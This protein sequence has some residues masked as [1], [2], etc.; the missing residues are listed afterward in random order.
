M[1]SATLKLSSHRL[2]VSG[3]QAKIFFF[4]IICDFC[5]TNKIWTDPFLKLH[6]LCVLLTTN[7]KNTDHRW[8]REYNTKQDVLPL[9]LAYIFTI[10]LST[11]GATGGLGGGGGGACP[12][13]A[14]SMM[15]RSERILLYQTKNRVNMPDTRKC[16]GLAR[17]PIQLNSSPTLNPHFNVQSILHHTTAR[18]YPSH[19]TQTYDLSGYPWHI[20]KAKSVETIIPSST[21]EHT[22]TP[23]QLLTSLHLL[24]F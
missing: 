7:T 11:R 10:Q 15:Q 18:I 20:L 4:S 8:R 24:L 6:N 9:M 23:I 17:C 12:N 13:R 21:H 2:K 3:I 16:Y 1:C 5:G 14:P 22:I 19:C